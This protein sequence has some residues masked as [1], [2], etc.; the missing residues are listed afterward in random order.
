MTWGPTESI[1]AVVTHV[2]VVLSAFLSFFDRQTQ[3][4]ASE[5]A[6]LIDAHVADPPIKKD[7]VAPLPRLVAI[8]CGYLL[9]RPWIERGFR[10]AFGRQGAA[11][12]HRERDAQD[13]NAND[14]PSARDRAGIAPWGTSLGDQTRSLLEQRRANAVKSRG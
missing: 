1:C 8:V 12:G 14:T 6:R 10:W 2:R 9:F 4:L 5:L 3:A 13:G 11:A 7:T